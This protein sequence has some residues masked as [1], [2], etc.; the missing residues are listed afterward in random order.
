MGS[1]MCIRDRVK[2]AQSLLNNLGYP[3][4]TPDGAMGPK[5]RGA[6]LNFQKDFGLEQTGKVNPEL[7]SELQ[8]ASA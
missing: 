7:L 8:R 3:V 5:T 1:E 6:I 2:S 4:G